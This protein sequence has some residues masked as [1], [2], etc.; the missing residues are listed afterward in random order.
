MS[1]S[2]PG[3]IISW[4]MMWMWRSMTEVIGVSGEFSILGLRISERNGEMFRLRF[5]LGGIQSPRSRKRSRL[6]G[7]VGLVRAELDLN[8]H[9]LTAE[10]AAPNSL[11]ADALCGH[12]TQR[13]APLQQHTRRIANSPARIPEL[14]KAS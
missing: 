7:G 2:G 14:P 3:F 4:G 9:P 8:P 5:G 10:G 6:Q 11:L 12:G 13:A 1:S